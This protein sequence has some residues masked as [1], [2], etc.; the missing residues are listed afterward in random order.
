MESNGG[1]KGNRGG[2]GEPNNNGYF[3]QGD[4]AGHLRKRSFS[5]AFVPPSQEGQMPPCSY[6]NGGG[7]AGTGIGRGLLPTPRWTG[8]GGYG[9]QEMP[10]NVD[11]RNEMGRTYNGHMGHNG[12]TFHHLDPTQNQYINRMLVRP[13]QRGKETGFQGIHGA[14]PLVRMPPV[15]GSSNYTNGST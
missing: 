15:A 12:Q 3:G 9:M 7:G 14:V 11:A 4:A 10:R 2:Q 13:S 5:Q 1:W 8:A 6:N